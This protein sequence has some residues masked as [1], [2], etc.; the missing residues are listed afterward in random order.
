MVCID[1]YDLFLPARVDCMLLVV[2]NWSGRVDDVDEDDDGAFRNNVTLHFRG[3]ERETWVCGG[4]G[5]MV[6]IIRSFELLK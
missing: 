5:W 1:R 3:R 6:C 4:Y 2:A